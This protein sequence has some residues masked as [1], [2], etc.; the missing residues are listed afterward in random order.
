MIPAT[1]FAAFSELGEKR[2]W[3]AISTTG[4]CRGALFDNESVQQHVC[5][6]ELRRRRTRARCVS[7]AGA[8]NNLRT[9]RLL[10]SVCPLPSKLLPAPRP[11]N[12]AAQDS[13][14]ALQSRILDIATVCRADARLIFAPLLKLA[15]GDEVAAFAALQGAREVGAVGLRDEDG[16]RG[17][18]GGWSSDGGIEAT[19]G[20][21]VIRVRGRAVAWGRGGKGRKEPQVMA[22]VV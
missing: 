12:R 17:H 15:L 16:W 22:G 21:L 9:R 19:V 14:I 2:R 8:L 18:G 3:Q 10:P 13:P 20:A 6:L 4:E 11:V 7:T 5:A 1:Q